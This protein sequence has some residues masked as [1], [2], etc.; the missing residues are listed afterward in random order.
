MD[1]GPKSPNNKFVENGR[2]NWSESRIKIL[3]Y[4]VKWKESHMHIY[5]KYPRTWPVSMIDN[6][7]LFLF[8]IVFLLPFS[9]FFSL[10]FLF[11]SPFSVNLLSCYILLFLHHFLHPRV[12]QVL[13]V[14][15]FYSP[16][17][18]LEPSTLNCKAACL[19][20]R[21][22][23]HI[24]ADAGV[25]VLPD[26]CFS[27]SLSFIWYFPIPF[28][29]K[30]FWNVT[31]RDWKVYW[32]PRTEVPRWSLSSD[33]VKFYIGILYLFLGYSF[34]L[35]LC[36]SSSDTLLSSDWVLGHRPIFFQYKLYLW[37]Q[38]APT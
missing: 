18:L 38:L 31:L 24:N 4:G 9:L 28:V 12:S 16:S 5:K 15:F 1:P 17:P 30:S 35:F 13:G 3:I 11:P 33:T 32:P 19:L 26:I 36:W 2:K 20:F 25:T 7:E 14:F 27:S 37:D 22:H 21:H 29:A 6:E 34:H 23:L 10:L 8:T